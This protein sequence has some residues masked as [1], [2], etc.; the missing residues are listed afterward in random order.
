[1]GGCFQSKRKIILEDYNR[2]FPKP[3]S[4]DIICIL[5]NE[6]GGE[7]NEEIKV[8]EL[9]KE[10]KRLNAALGCVFGA[11]IGD[12]LG[13][14]IEFKTK[15]TNDDL[16][17]ALL[18]KGGIF[19]NGPGQVTD[20][21]ELGMCLLNGVNDALPNFSLE[22]I[23]SY[24]KKWIESNP[25]D[26]GNTTRSAFGPLQGQTHR[27]AEIAM[28]ASLKH[29]QNSKSN[30]SFMRSSP[31]AVWGRRLNAEDL[32]KI[33]QLETSLTHPNETIAQAESYY[34]LF[35]S[36]LIQNPKDINGA[37]KYSNEYLQK[38]N[39][40]VNLWVKES[41]NEKPIPGSPNIGYAK[42]AFEHALRQIRKPKIDFT[43][44]MKE[45]LLLGGD[46]DTN[47]CIVGAMIGAYVGYD[48]LPSNWKNKVKNFDQ[49]IVGGI[50]RPSF[51]DQKKVE[52]L[53][54][55]IF[56][57]APSVMKNTD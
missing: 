19:G 15:I 39:K 50:L 6:E 34:I 41:K 42:I 28:Q 53:V 1:M 38:C 5:N 43:E 30:G 40:E 51:L 17:R 47:A 3:Y 10:T 49:T 12:S 55:K 31:L 22:R 56:N 20:D 45:I 25:F 36:Y 29:N 26:I 23:A 13:S 14:A 11:F 37:K 46:T 44:S 2:E 32:V 7:V 57:Q 35:I 8:K 48:E 24:Y 18:M 52:E 4:N 9:E 33:V 16:D 27:L 21:S 54:T